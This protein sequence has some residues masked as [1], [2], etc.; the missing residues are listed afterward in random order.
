MR[1]CFALACFTLLLAAHSAL[2]ATRAEGLALWLA[3]GPDCNTCKIYETAAERRAYGDHLVHGELSLPIVHVDKRD[4]SAHVLSQ[5]PKDIGPRGPHWELQ[6]IVLVMGEQERVLFAGNIAESADMR[7]LRYDEQVMFPPAQPEAHHPALSHALPYADFFKAQWNLEYFVEVAVDGRRPREEIALVDLRAP[8]PYEPAPR[9]VLWGSASTPLANATFVST[10]LAEAQRVFAA[11]SPQSTRVTLHGHGPA[12]DGN[13][14][15]L[16][17][18]GAVEFR[19]GDVA[20]EFAATADD[21]NAV[22]SGIRQTPRARTLLF[23]AGHAGPT[24]APL[25]GHGLTLRPLHLAP[26]GDDGGELIM[27]SGACH[28]GQF[29]EAVSCGFFA[30]H[31]A[32]TATGCQLSA[33]AIEASDDYLNLLLGF[34][35]DKARRDEPTSLHAAHWYAS[36][37]LEHHQVPYSTSDHLIAEALA[38]GTWPSVISARSLRVNADLLPNAEASALRHLLEGMDPQQSVFL[39]DVVARNHAAS[40]VLRDA[41]ELTS[42]QRNAA[43]D[44]PYPLSLAL[45]AR[46]VV[47][48]QQHPQSPALEATLA[49]ETQPLRAFLA[50]SP[51]PMTR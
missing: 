35:D 18:D 25:W 33:E 11:L 41:R 14:E 43:I 7:A 6:L 28:G 40:Q 12:V 47:Y 29:A 22:L 51:A 8:V 45:L 3:S 36:A 20:R 16:L 23:Q 9:L 21:L 44:L 19:R 50:P 10:R 30:A 5:L 4:L 17:V 42:A 13:D 39:D 49:C 27:V 38:R 24:G 15:S 31:P 48:R 26:L 32:V 1:F 37:R 34:L 46:R 2:G